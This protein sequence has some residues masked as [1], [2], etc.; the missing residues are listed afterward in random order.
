MKVQSLSEKA[1]KFQSAHIEIPFA[2]EAGVLIRFIEIDNWIHV[3]MDVGEDTTTQDLRDTI[4]LALTWRDKLLEW[5]GAWLGGGD[6]QF[7]E[8]LSSRQE[9]GESYSELAKRINQTVTELLKEFNEYL[10]EFE[11]ARSNFVTMLDFYLWKSKANQFSL[12]QAQDILKA[13]RLKDDEIKEMLQVGL[14]NIQ[15]GEQAFEEEYPLSK[16]KLRTTLRS[17]RQG[18]KHLIAKQMQEEQRQKLD[19]MK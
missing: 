6:N 1:G 18:R 4:P 11:A 14:K 16:E 15:S 3:M 2:S 13:L 5:Q 7:L 17:W 10:I 19:N 9:Y 8:E 12:D